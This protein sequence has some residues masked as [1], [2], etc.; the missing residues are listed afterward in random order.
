M[1]EPADILGEGLPEGI[2]EGTMEAGDVDGHVQA[3]PHIIHRPSTSVTSEWSCLNRW[4][5]KLVVRDRAGRCSEAAELLYMQLGAGQQ[6]EGTELVGL[7][8]CPQVGVKI[9]KLSV[10]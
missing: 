7:V 5:S 10:E 1:C 2:G 3:A 8:Q 9:S 4:M 6:E